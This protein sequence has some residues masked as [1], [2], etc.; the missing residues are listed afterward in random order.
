M[1]GVS[2]I[3]AGITPFGVRS[4]SLV[5]LGAIAC[6][7]ALEDAGIAPKPSSGKIT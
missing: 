2:I 4:E 5:A 6:K 7:N 3:G 1:R